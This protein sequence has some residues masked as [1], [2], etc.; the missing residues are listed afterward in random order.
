[1]SFILCIIIK[2][3]FFSIYSILWGQILLKKDGSVLEGTNITF[4]TTNHL[5]LSL[6]NRDFS[7]KFLASNNIDKITLTMSLIV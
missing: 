3:L 7:I 6:V 2:P 4:S 5:S 1:M